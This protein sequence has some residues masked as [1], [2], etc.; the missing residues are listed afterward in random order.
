MVP[1]SAI[2]IT[3]D[4]ECLTCSG[5]SLGKPIRLGNF[6]FIA[7]YFDGLSLSIGGGD[8]GTTFMGSTRR[9]ASTLWQAT[10]EDSAEV[11]LT[12]TP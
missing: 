2:T 3:T 11:F 8:S 4:G 5:F 12:T 9:A 6:N 10:T 1:S 7:D